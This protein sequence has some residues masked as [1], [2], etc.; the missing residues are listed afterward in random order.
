[1]TKL[2]DNTR[3]VLLHNVS[4]RYGVFLQQW[5]DKWR[6]VLRFRAPTEFSQCEVCFQTTQSIKNAKDLQHRLQHVHDLKVHLQNVFSDRSLLWSMVAQDPFRSESPVIHIITDGMDQSHWSIPRL[7]GHRPSSVLSKLKRPRCCVQGVWA[8]HGV[9]SFYVLDA[10]MP[11]DPDSVIECVARTIEK[12]SEEFVLRRKAM[13]KEI[14]LIVM[15]SVAQSVVCTA[16]L[17]MLL[18]LITDQSEPLPF[19]PLLHCQSAFHVA[20]AILTPQPHTK[21]DNTVRENKNA[22]TMLY[23]AMLVAKL[24]FTSASHYSLRVGHTH[25]CLGQRLNMF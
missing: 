8:F 20:C 17:L 3:G 9:L 4:L 11:H 7:R 13:P 24:N 15:R 1:M 12:L 23:L 16:H 25:E 6:K 19:R 14:I 2:H 18:K 21:A 5:N 22:P 10:T